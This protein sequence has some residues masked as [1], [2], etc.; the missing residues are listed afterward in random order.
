MDEPWKNIRGEAY[1][2]RTRDV[3][4]GLAGEVGFQFLLNTDVGEYRAGRVVAL[5]ERA[6]D[7][8]GSVG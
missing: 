8:E 7:E 1:K 4:L 5:G 2:S 6:D 3:L